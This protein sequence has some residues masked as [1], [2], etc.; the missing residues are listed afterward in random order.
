MA[1]ETRF[2]QLNLTWQFSGAILIEY[3]LVRPRIFEFVQSL[4]LVPHDRDMEL[5][6]NR[7]P[8]AELTGTGSVFF[9]YK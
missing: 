7:V 8:D 6:F 4:A 5:A 3:D 1:A 9:P 2:V